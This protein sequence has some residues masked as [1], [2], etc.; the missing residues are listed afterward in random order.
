[1]DDTTRLSQA[2]FDRLSAELRDLSTRG[3]ID[4]AQ[5][6][7]EAR[8]MGDL[9]ENGDYQAAKEEQGKMEGRI[10]LLESLLADVEIVE[11]VDGDTV[12]PGVTLELRFDG[13]DETE[14]Y[15]FG[16]IEENAPEVEVLTP[17]SPLGEAVAGHRAG[18]TVRYETPGGSL[19][20]EIVAI[21][22]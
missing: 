5:Q 6:I 8:L 10:R 9:S 4:I 16:S 13:D 7:E 18:D 22:T 15:L 14:R 21:S 12:A 11:S 20:V 19:A 2:A 1:M 17:G 3:R